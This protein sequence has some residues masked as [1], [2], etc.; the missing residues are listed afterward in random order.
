MLEYGLASIAGVAGV[1]SKRDIQ[2]YW[3]S[4]PVMQWGL[5]LS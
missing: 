3:D 5:T 4:C 2:N 1:Y